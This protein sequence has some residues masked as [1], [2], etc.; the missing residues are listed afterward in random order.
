MENIQ[1]ENI[2]L[3]EKIVKLKYKLKSFHDIYVK[4]FENEKTIEEF[5]KDRLIYINKI[6]MV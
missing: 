6:R 5:N 4:K 3:T 2:H 1:S